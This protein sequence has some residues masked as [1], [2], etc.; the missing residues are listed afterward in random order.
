MKASKVIKACRGIGDNLRVIASD[1]NWIIEA[2]DGNIGFR[3]I[4]GESGRRS[5]DTMVS[6]NQFAS[7]ATMDSADLDT[8]DG[9]LLIK[10]K[11]ASAVYNAASLKIKF[12]DY[13][14][15]DKVAEIHG[16]EL[17]E[18]V[19]NLSRTTLPSDAGVFRGVVFEP[20]VIWSSDRTRFTWYEKSLGFQAVV[21]IDY[22]T[23]IAH[24]CRGEHVTIFKD[25]GS[26]IFSV[27]DGKA[28]T[29]LLS[30]NPPDVSKLFK[31]GKHT[32]IK[33][34]AEAMV[35]TLGATT[36]FNKT[37]YLDITPEHVTIRSRSEEGQSE[38][39]IDCEANETRNIAINGQFLLDFL[40]KSIGAVT[41]QVDDGKMILDDNRDVNYMVALMEM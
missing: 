6:Y 18:M 15:A 20:D 40:T 21:P 33:F 16:D 34:D 32:N 38:G 26:L 22:L 4:I 41:A 29:A 13:E 1:N 14:S 9:K 10:S 3:G 25:V 37:T 35:K 31:I 11:Y 12:P 7:L 27:P 17:N 2:F 30:V 24:F 39:T 28:S 19:S 23:K 5:I 36:S 8:Q